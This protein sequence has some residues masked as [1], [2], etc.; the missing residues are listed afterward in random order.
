MDIHN[1]SRE[2]SLISIPRFI[3]EVLEPR[4]PISKAQLLYELEEHNAPEELK[5]AIITNVTDQGVED[6]HLYEEIEAFYP[7]THTIE[8]FSWFD[9]DDDYS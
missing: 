5:D 1:N 8:S 9:E 6:D 7:E 4:L 2:S 3:K